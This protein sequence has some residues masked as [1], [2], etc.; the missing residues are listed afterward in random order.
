M[1]DKG[2]DALVKIVLAVVGVLSLW[3]GQRNA[4]QAE[5]RAANTEVWVDSLETELRAEQFA[6]DVLEAQE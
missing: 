2:W 6:I 5:V 4:Q 3:L 1:S